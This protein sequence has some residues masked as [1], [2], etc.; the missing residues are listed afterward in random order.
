ME[1]TRVRAVM[2]TTVVA[3]HADATYDEI[4][5][6]L[7]HHGVSAVPV[8]DARIAV[9]GVVSEA[10][11][12]PKVE[13]SDDDHHP[14]LPEDGRR[15]VTRV[16]TSGRTAADLMTEPPIT[17]APDA[18]L[19]DAARLMDAHRVKRLPVVT[20]EGLLVGI[21]SRCDLLRGHRRSSATASAVR[22]LGTRA[23]VPA[24]PHGSA[25]DW[26]W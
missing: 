22:V 15:G 12:L 17:I 1:T 11:L 26:G 13:F 2:T 14:M 21:V 4:A 24:S 9:I 8:V 18:S 20:G 10:D 23:P 7:D 3:V 25:D 19:V 6:A 5:D 16:K